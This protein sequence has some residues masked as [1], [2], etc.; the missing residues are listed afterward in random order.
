MRSPT[1]SPRLCE[2]C[3]S[4]GPPA[5]MAPKE[6]QRTLEQQRADVLVDAILG[7]LSGELP[8]RHGLPQHIGV[9]VNLD[10]PA[11]PRIHQPSTQRW[12]IPGE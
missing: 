7:G 3:N 2:R 10:Q 4:T 8:A 5:R 12:K 9:I 6:D 11:R 1:A